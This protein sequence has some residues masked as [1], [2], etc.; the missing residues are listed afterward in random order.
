MKNYERYPV[1]FSRSGTAKVDSLALSLFF[2]KGMVNNMKMEREYVLKDDFEPIC[3]VRLVD[4]KRAAL[5]LSLPRRNNYQSAFK[6]GE[7]FY[8]FKKINIVCPN[9]GMRLHLYASKSDSVSVRRLENRKM[10]RQVKAFL[11]DQIT[12]FDDENHDYIEINA[13][14]PFGTKVECPRCGTQ[15]TL[16]EQSSERKVRIAADTDK[17]SIACERTDIFDALSIGWLSV[18]NKDVAIGLPPYEEKIIFDF[19]TGATVIQLIDGSGIVCEKEITSDAELAGHDRIVDVFNNFVLRRRIRSAF[20]EAYGYEIFFTPDELNLDRYIL[21]TNFMGYY[22]DFYDCV[23]FIMDYRPASCGKRRFPESIREIAKF[24]HRADDIPA[25]YNKLGLPVV[26]SVRKIV[27]ENPQLMFYAYELQL[28]NKVF[29][30]VN[31]FRRIITCAAAYRILASLVRSG[32][33]VDYLV[34]LREVLG[35]RRLYEYMKNRDCS[36][37][38]SN[39]IMYSAMNDEDKAFVRSSLMNSPD[40]FRNIAMLPK[41]FSLNVPMN[42][43]R[44]QRYDWDYAGFR[45]KTLRTSDDYERAGMDLHNCLNARYGCDRSYDDEEINDNEV[46]LSQNENTIVGV[47]KNGKYVGAVD[48]YYD[49]TVGFSAI[50]YNRPVTRDPRFFNAYVAWLKRFGLLDTHL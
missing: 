20:A 17:L 21:H 29:P 18:E 25:L 8:A 12:F 28:L 30:D 48:V 44:K 23:P 31:Y 46:I 10:D 41:G 13:P 9:C 24:M 35:M 16:R 32:M 14:L 34:M 27:F 1:G 4:K 43:L 6:S 15:G 2:S 22:R 11:D 47:I 45:F 37:I 49:G 19:D 36:F 33:A 3:E 42:H 26:K 7:L 39:G 50:E 40:P 38:F 5:K